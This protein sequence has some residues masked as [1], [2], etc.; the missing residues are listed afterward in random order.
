MSRGFCHQG[1][2][3]FFQ[4]LVQRRDLDSKA[5][6][7]ASNQGRIPFLAGLPVLGPQKP[8]TWEDLFS[9]GSQVPHGAGA[10]GRAVISMWKGRLL[11]EHPV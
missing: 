1:D 7:R 9:D 6:C 3:L 5:P 11:L 8:F 2:E 4:W 10:F